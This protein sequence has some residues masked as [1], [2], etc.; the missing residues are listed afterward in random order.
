MSTMLSNVDQA[1]ASGVLRFGASDLALIRRTACPAHITDDEFLRFIHICVHA[2]LNPLLKQ[3]Y[4]FI[5]SPNDEQK[6]HMD[7]I[8]GIHGLTAVAAR[9]GD[10]RGSSEP[11]KYVYNDDEKN[12]HTN[13]I[14]LVS[15]FVTLYKYSHSE[16]F[17]QVGEAYWDEFA[18]I[19]EEGEGGFE[20]VETGGVWEDSG[21]PKKKKVPLGNI[22]RKLEPGKKSW[23]K[24]QRLMLA[25]CAKSQALRE[26]WPEDCS[27]LYSEDE[28]DRG[29]TL[30]LNAVEIVA[31]AEKEARQGKIGGPGISIDWL[32]GG[33]IVTV[34]ADEFFGKA[35]DFIKENCEEPST[36]LA[37]RDRNRDALRHYYV[38]KPDEAF[39]LKEALDTVK[40]IEAAE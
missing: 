27:A 25:K 11:I 12:E 10:Y 34:K 1:K 32:D 36:V 24:M 13:P 29:M 39:Q 23:R 22:I 4:C 38:L 35:K 28:M 26:G 37:W 14:G 15:A 7:V 5:F 30:E 6:R 21:K 3:C 20:W 9:A 8:T 31:E 40:L 19:I 18:P 16:W 17:P 2:G 33:P